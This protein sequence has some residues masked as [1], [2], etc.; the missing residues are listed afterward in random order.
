[1]PWYCFHF[2]RSSEIHSNSLAHQ[3][4]KTYS[5]KHQSSIPTD[6]LFTPKCDLIGYKRWYYMFA[7]DMRDYM[8]LIREFSGKM[9]IPP[10]STTLQ[11]LAGEWLVPGW[12]DKFF[13]E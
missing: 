10:P 13:R 5:S 1:M 6:G 4:A 3:F 11:H 7:A 9:C 8:D 2:G 12:E